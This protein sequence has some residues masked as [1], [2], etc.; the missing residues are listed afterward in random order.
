MLLTNDAAAASRYHH[1]PLLG[2]PQQHYAGYCRTPAPAVR[3]AAPGPRASA[4]SS[5]CS[6]RHTSIA[7]TTRLLRG[8]TAPRL[9]TTAS[10]RLYQMAL[11]PA[12]NNRCGRDIVR[13][14]RFVLTRLRRL[15]CHHSPF[16]TGLMDLPCFC[17]PDDS[18]P[19]GGT[20]CRLR[21]CIP[22]A[23]PMRTGVGP[24]ARSNSYT[25][26]QTTAKRYRAFA[27]RTDA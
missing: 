11:T 16:Q 24:P 13:L 14:G 2:L 5:G 27:S 20:G 4:F 18:P 17:R 15:P 6:Q 21:P 9:T 19:A 26:V 8:E 7:G 1:C 25:T 3:A 23:P 12:L 10:R 22:T